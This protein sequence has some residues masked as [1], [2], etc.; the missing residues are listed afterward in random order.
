MND[1]E[2]ARLDGPTGATCGFCKGVNTFVDDIG[3]WYISEKDIKGP[4]RACCKDC[5][6][7]PIGDRHIERYGLGER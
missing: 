3:F 5:Y 6:D 1:L 2:R 4:A 7:G